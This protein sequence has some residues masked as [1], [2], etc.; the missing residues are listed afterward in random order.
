MCPQCRKNLGDDA[1]GAI[2]GGRH[3]RQSPMRLTRSALVRVLVALP[4]SRLLPIAPAHALIGEVT[5]LGF[6]QAD[7]K[8]WDMTLPSPAWSIDQSSPPRAE[9]PKRLFHVIATR[10]EGAVADVTVVPSGKKSRTELGKVEQVGA[11]LA[12]QY[13]E[14]VRT[15]AVVGKINGKEI[16]GSLY[17]IIEYKLANGG[18]TTLKLD[19]KQGRTYTLAVTLP[20]KPSAALKAEADALLESFKC[21]PVNAICI[22]Q[23]AGGKTPLAATCY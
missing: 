17:Y 14:L 7:D 11:A 8:S 10:A 15:D 12:P 6:Y 20:A 4:A 21:F 22:S 1:R 9:H 23:S 18:S 19:A 2:S 5:G 3:K 16:K 13:G